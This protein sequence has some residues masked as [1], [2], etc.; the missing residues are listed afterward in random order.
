VRIPVLTSGGAGAPEIIS[1]GDELLPLDGVA[2]DAQGNI[3]ALV[4][5]QSKLVR[6][7]PHDGIVTTLA[8]AEDGLDFPASLAFGTREEDRHSVFVTNYAIGPPGGVGPSVV[9]IDVGTV[10][11]LP[12][13]GGAAF[14]PT[15]LA[16]ALG[17]LAILGGLG[18]ALSSRPPRQA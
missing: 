15:I 4:I 17:G 16:M 8:T 9:K 13:T 2:L 7:D 1:A 12:E 3:Y 6:I 14:S 5:A 18:L 10:E 11:L